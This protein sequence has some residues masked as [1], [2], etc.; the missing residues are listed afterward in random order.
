M[1]DDELDALIRNGKLDEA[2][3]LATARWKAASASGDEASEAD[4]LLDE[5][6]AQ[7]AHGDREDAVMTVDEAIF[8]ARRTFG[9]ADARY[10]AALELGAEIAAEAEMPSTADAR[11]RAAIEVL[12][13]GGVAGAPLLHALYHHGLF[14]RTRNDVEGAVRAYAAVVERA[15]D[16][17]DRA[18]LP[19]LAMALAGLG[20]I[21]LE[22]GRDAEARALGDRALEAWLAVGQARRFEVADA[23]VVVGTAALRLGDAAPAA[24]FLET[25]REIYRGCKVDVRA[26]H[27]AAA[28][29]H[30]R[31]LEALGRMEDART[32]YREALGLYR[33]GQP[34]RMSVEQR[35]LELARD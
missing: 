13:A 22:A 9:A 27:A 15:R 35:L 28:T 18:V 4:A 14:R 3:K 19:S 30:A 25:A 17:D 7:F 5:A 32:A 29:D 1:S 21:A 11:F 2:L 12:E 31:A 8:K 16:A 20:T 34:E 26:R 23:M 6:R 24:Q 33:E 10:A